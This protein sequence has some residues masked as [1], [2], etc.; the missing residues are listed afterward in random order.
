MEVEDAARWS[1]HEVEDLEAVEGSSSSDKELGPVV[2]DAK[3]VEGGSWS[4]ME[5][6][7]GEDWQTALEPDPR[8]LM[9]ADG[10]KIQTCRWWISCESDKSVCYVINRMILGTLCGVQN[11]IIRP[12]Q[13]YRD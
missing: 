4:D 12:E 10:R 7:F 1:Y 3:V 2:E 6:D 13:S 11:V 9:D 5:A 8:P